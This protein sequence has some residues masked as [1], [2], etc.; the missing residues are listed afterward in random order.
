LLKEV[1]FFLLSLDELCAKSNTQFEKLFSLDI[2]G[3]VNWQVMLCEHLHGGLTAGSAKLRYQ[4]PERPH[5][6]SG[7]PIPPVVEGNQAKFIQKHRVFERG[8]ENFR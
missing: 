1:Y 6:I 3:L 4:A 5:S 7:S 8:E 2:P